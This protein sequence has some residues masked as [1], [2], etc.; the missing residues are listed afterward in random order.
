MRATAEEKSIV[1]AAQRRMR[2]EESVR[3]EEWQPLYF[4]PLK[5]DP[6]FERLSRILTEDVDADA[7]GRIWKVDKDAVAHAHR[8]Y[9]G[10]LRPTGEVQDYPVDRDARASD[11]VPAWNKPDVGHDG[12]IRKSLGKMQMK[13]IILR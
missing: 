10:A 7:K 6:V 5:E 1:E 11:A 9:R 8:P 4:K 12:H 13:S 2:K 3:S